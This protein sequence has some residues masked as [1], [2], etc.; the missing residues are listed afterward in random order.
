MQSAWLKYIL[1]LL[2][3]A[4]GAASYAYTQFLIG[5][6][7]ERNRSSVELWARAIEYIAR[8][9]GSES[10]ESQLDFVASELVIRDRFQVPAVLTDE[11]G[12]I[13]I[14]R[15]V[16]STD[17]GAALLTRFAALN[18]PILVE[19]PI[20]NGQTVRQFIYYGETD[21][22]RSLRYFPYIQFGLIALVF[23]LAYLSWSSVRRN[24]QSRVWVGMAKEAAHQL[25]TPLSSILG[26]IELLKTE[27]PDEGD[28]QEHLRELEEDASRLQLVADRFNK[29]GSSPELQVQR[30]DPVLNG[31]TDYIGRRIP[32]F[33]KQVA[34]ERE[35]D[36]HIK[37]EANAEL[38]T[39][40]FENLLKNALDAIEPGTGEARI[41]VTAFQ[42]QGRC[43]V[44]IADTGKGIE[45]KHHADIFKPGF[46]TKRRGW[47]LG[48]S[49][50]R[51]IIED[52]HGGTVS[53]LRSAPG[54]G[55]V[56]RVT[57][58]SVA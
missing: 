5:R 20:G 15:N 7:V 4:I 33:G 37:I 29:I 50:T 2:L 19:I 57:L 52:Y 28:A 54:E 40:A 44:D 22:I 12:T 31:V 1:I 55:T 6:I 51:R 30:L 25:G 38:L 23:G 24:E 49:L 3:A 39:W 43:L 11:N 45:K 14:H 27:L 35:I 32:R 9:A 17:L 42:E 13:L 41:R 34:L 56:I 53:V 26:W 36:P 8:E 58:R 46:S 18:E 48:L 16:D 47:G 21:S 10:A